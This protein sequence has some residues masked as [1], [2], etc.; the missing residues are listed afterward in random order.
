MVTTLDAR[1]L[2][3]NF[4]L[5]EL[6][7]SKEHPVLAKLLWPT[8]YEASNLHMLCVTILQ[9]VRTRFGVEIIPT[10]GFRDPRLN[11][12]VGGHEKSLHPEGKAGDFTTP[13]VTMLPAMFEYIRVELPFAWLQLIYYADRNFIHVGLPHFGAPRICEVRGW[14]KVD[15]FKGGEGYGGS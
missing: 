14:G 6:L 5:H 12:A 2:T 4:R 13:D 11:K 9:P 15:H 10:S 8:T 7:V 3:D 1:Q